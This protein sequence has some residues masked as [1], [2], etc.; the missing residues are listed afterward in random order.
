MCLGPGV[1]L[2][3]FWAGTYLVW[4]GNLTSSGDIYI[5]KPNLFGGEDER[6]GLQGTISFY[7]GRF[8]PPQD[9]Y[10]VSKIGPNVPAYNGFARALF[11]AFYIGTGTTPEPFSF[12]IQ[13]ITSG[14]HATYSIMPNGLDVNPME[15]VYDA[16]T[17]KWGRFGNL[18]SEI[19]MPS[20]T[21]CAQTLYNE[22]LGMSLIVQSAI[23]GKDLLEEVMRVADGVLYQDPATAKIV[24]KLGYVAYCSICD[25]RKR[26]VGRSNARRRRRIVSRPGNGEDCCETCSPRLH[27]FRTSCS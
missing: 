8:D 21:A 13:R 1:R 15:I 7:D 2:R 6:G 14:L 5:N 23:T 24:A 4:E 11:K 18:E 9:S 22:G 26:L 17:Q 12:E 25:Y 20:F 19:D 10:L 3:K 16:M 27:D